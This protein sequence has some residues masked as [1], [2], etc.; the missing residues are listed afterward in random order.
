MPKALITGASGFIGRHVVP[1]L[2]EKGYDVRC[3]VRPTSDRGFLKRYPVEF[4]DGD[5]TDFDSLRPA[6]DAVDFVFHMAGVAQVVANRRFFDLHTQGTINTAKACLARQSPPRLIHISSLAAM[7]PAR[8]GKPVTETDFAKPI[9]PYGKSKHLA[10]LELR[11]RADRIPCTIV[12]PPYVIGEGD[13]A[14]TALFQMIYKQRIHLIPGY[15][16]NLYSFVHAEDLANLLA[17]VA[18]DGERLTKNSLPT[19]PEDV[20]PEL[21]RGIYNASCGEFVTFG[22]FGRKIAQ[23][24]GI[25]KIRVFKTPPMACVVGSL[26]YEVVKKITGKQVP[27]DWNKIREALR[28]PWIC[29]DEK[30][31][32]QFGFIP[33]P[34]QKRIEQTARWYR[35]SGLF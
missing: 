21:G 11:D 23:A 30:A 1:H 2:I 29:D 35:D 28:G 34:F 16:N 25:E 5:V 12:R 22:D 9:S 10:E 6:V 26:F 8:N 31:R 20:S 27:F 3:L 19:T 18:V 17:R 14:S 13:H 32:T 15:F 33:Q 4:I 7:G 24:Y